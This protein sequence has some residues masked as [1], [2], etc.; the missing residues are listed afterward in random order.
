[1]VEPL[2][3]H[4]VEENDKRVKKLNKKLPCP[5]TQAIGTAAKIGLTKAAEEALLAFDLILRKKN[6]MAVDSNLNAQASE[7]IPKKDPP[8]QVASISFT[9]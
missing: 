8:Q 6:A 9:D 2:D 7:L 5:V 4:I 1:M 3:I